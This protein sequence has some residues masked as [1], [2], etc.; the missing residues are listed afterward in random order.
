[1]IS[2]EYSDASRIS[3]VGFGGP[4]VLK[5]GAHGTKYG[6]DNGVGL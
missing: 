4:T 1:M 2:L 3:E 5:K 6:F